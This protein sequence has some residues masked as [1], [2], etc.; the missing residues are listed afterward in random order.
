MKKKTK[1]KIADVSGA[2]KAKA[3]PATKIKFKSPID[4]SVPEDAIVK[5][6]VKGK[7]AKVVLPATKG[8]SLVIVE[9]PAK[10]KTISKILG[11][12]Y[13]I[14]SSYGH[15]RDLPKS[16]LGIDIE[17]NFKPGYIIMR[18]Q[19]KNVNALKKMAAASN[20]VYLATDPD[21]EGEAIA[22]HLS[23]ILGMPPDKFWRVSFDEITA[24]AVK[25]AFSHPRKI[26]ITLVNAQQTRRFLDRIMGYKLSPLLWDKITRGLSAGR[27]Q[28]VAL[29]LVVERERAIRSFKPQEHWKITADLSAHQGKDIFN[30]TLY[31]LNDSNV[32]SPMDGSANIWIGSEAESKKLVERL[33]ASDFKVLG[34]TERDSNQYPAP[35]FITSTLQQT[36]SIKLNFSPRKTMM[37]AQQLYEGVDLPEGPAGLITY[38]RTDSVRVSE[39]A[40]K[41]CRGFITKHF[42]EGLLNPEARH[43]KPSKQSQQAHEAIRPTY[44]AKMPD[45]IAQYLTRDQ[46]KLYT[47]IWKRF[48]A[49]QM[50]PAAWKSKSVEIESQLAPSLE[51]EVFSNDKRHK[52]IAE[53]ILAAISKG[54]NGAV[55]EKIITILSR[56]KQDDETARKIIEALGGNVEDKALTARIIGIMDETVDG[57]L[58]LEK[59]NVARC[60]WSANERRLVAPG[61]MTLYNPEEQLLPGLKESGKLD[62]AQIIPAQSFTEPPPYYNEA[63]LVKVLEKYG[64]GRPSTYAPI[65][66]TIQDRGY[67]IKRA[68]QLTPTDLGLLV[69]D[70]LVPFFDDIINT[71]FTARIE[72]ELDLIEEGKKEL[73]PTLKEFYAP[74]AKDL[75]K[76]QLEMTSEKGKQS[77]GNC[78]LCNN[79]IVERWSRFGKFLS[80]S[81]FPECRHTASLKPKQEPEKTD[82][83]CEKCGKPMV[84]R[85]NRRR[86]TRFI[87]CSG[88]PDCKNAKPFKKP[89]EE[90]EA[91]PEPARKQNPSVE[92]T[93]SNGASSEEAT[94]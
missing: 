38:M 15:I 55:L 69:N 78:P 71:Q 43:Y 18:K 46:Y 33:K 19:I 35:P 54:E 74:F 40:I 20:G 7:K 67:V 51:L 60:L 91:V 81:A 49:T 83:V 42:G 13:V 4:A 65:I 50:K 25:E 72:E 16:K 23:E 80:C 75:E 27:V 94:N 66:A 32:G 56:N 28:S 26:S 21:R 41:E 6:A 11:D 61:F 82:Q 53:K 59:M 30:A 88:Y 2:S 89:G 52:I 79:P 37:I 1:K 84:I 36:A 63:S 57:A 92:D 39:V 93:E 9:S 47:L 90:A 14:T 64:I 10:I 87:A 12:D 62:V 34:I 22:W 86:R 73:V 17:D 8:K 48:T 24:P 85:F 58:I 31:K 45:D 44:P 70:K 29:R 5:P 3:K 68:R 77:G 76:A